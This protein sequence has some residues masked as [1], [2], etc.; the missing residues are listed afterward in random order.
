ML[1]GKGH[2]I[3]LPDKARDD[4]R[5]FSKNFAFV[6]FL[7]RTLQSLR[8][9][10]PVGS[11]RRMALAQAACLAEFASQII[12]IGLRVLIWSHGPN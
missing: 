1:R 6:A 5:D 10:T 12:T 7:S 2:S 8:R 9:S 4:A 11:T 3:L